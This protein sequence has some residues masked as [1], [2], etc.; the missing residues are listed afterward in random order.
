MCIFEGAYYIKAQE[1]LDKEKSILEHAPLFRKRFNLQKS[2]K[3]KLYVQALGYGVFYLNEKPITEDLFI[4]P[5]SNYNKVLWYNIYDVTS[6][7]NEGEN[8]I[9]GILGNGFYNEG[10]DTVWK[11]CDAPWRD[12]PKFILKLVVDEETKIV[13]DDSWKC[14]E[15]SFITYNQL[16]AGETYNAIFHDKNWTKVDY[17]DNFWKYAIKD[18]N[19][20]KGIF[21]E[22]T[23]PPIREEEYYKPISI[24]QTGIDTIVYDFGVNI[25][26]FVRIQV[27]GKKGQT[28]TIRYA[29]EIDEKGKLELNNLDCYY[30]NVEF[31][32]DKMILSGKKDSYQPF[33]TYHGFRFAEVKG[34]SKVIN[35]ISAVFIHQDIKK[36]ANFVCGND[37]LNKIYNAGIRS[38]LSNAHYTFTD[39]PTREKLGWLNDMQATVK[40]CLYNFDSIALYEKILTDLHYEID[41]QGAFPAIIPSYGW[42]KHNGPVAEGFLFEVPYRYYLLTG[43]SRLLKEYL[44]DFYR[45]LKYLKNRVEKKNRYVLGDWLGFQNAPTPIDF[46]ERAYLY[47]FLGIIELTEKINGNYEKE[48]EL[49]REKNAVLSRLIKEYYAE[50]ETCKIEEQTALAISL[51]FHIN[52]SKKIK[53]QL[54]RRVEQDNFQNKCGMVGTQFIYEALTICQKSNYAYKMLTET[55]IGYKLW[56]KNGAT[57]LWETWN[58]IHNGSHNHHMFSSCIGWMMS[59][60]L[61]VD[62]DGTAK[63]ILLNPCFVKEVGFVEGYIG[64]ENGRVESRWEFINNKIKYCVIVPEGYTAKYKEKILL[65]GKYEFLEEEYELEKL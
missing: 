64:L 1:T 33:F 4:S 11:Y 36:K 27:Q 50:D 53:E 18:S 20:P 57:T 17:K 47:R 39:C 13:T 25:S 30:N 31:Q 2:G 44:P 23:C 22:C 34:A 32:V 7:L 16:R 29:E 24:M 19:I 14:N 3:A 41:E 35:D 45:Y 63:L 46:I 61:G 38:I 40:T 52:E 26:G 48:K 12:V 54:V 43:N 51:A 10:L 15:K 65:P 42:G 59:S 21:L 28:I 37:L 58:G 56:F 49:S 8:V 62:F 55:E 60:L 6:L 5:V 9:C